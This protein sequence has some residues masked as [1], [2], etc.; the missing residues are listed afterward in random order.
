[1][2]S[3]M[4]PANTD[5][6]KD[7]IIGVVG[8]SH[9][10]AQEIL[11]ALSQQHFPKDQIRA[12][13]KQ[14]GH[15]R[16]ASYGENDE[17]DIE[18]L[19]TLTQGK[20][21][22]EVDILIF[23]GERKQ[24][25]PVQKRHTK[26]NGIMLD[27]SGAFSMHPD[28]PMIVPEINGQALEQVGSQRVI[29][30]PH[31]TTAMIAMCVMPLLTV[32]REKNADAT[33]RVHATI[34][35][36]VSHLGR[37]AMDELFNHTKSVF[38]NASPE[39]NI[40]PVPLPFNILPRTSGVRADE[41]SFDEWTVLTQLKKLFDGAIK[42]SCHI[43]QAPVFV[44]D[45]ITMD[46]DAGIEITPLNAMKHLSVAPGIGVVET[47]DGFDDEPV[48]QAVE[49]EDVSELF[50]DED[51]DTVVT[52]VEVVGEDL[53]F[54][55]RVRQDIMSPSGLQMV[56]VGDNL[57]C[58]VGLTVIKLVDLWLKRHHTAAEKAGA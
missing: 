6:A 55:T 32:A 31:P 53:C 36:S 4:K 28:V 14:G 52:P 11:V 3:Q 8:V 7:T 39:S 51:A 1:M 9:P 41:H 56:A 42:P 24:A 50:T 35:R 29:S 27:L 46:V 17:I 38:M 49:T 43:V 21:G 20:A 30:V 44:G 5:Y 34:M 33:L 57:R 25:A 16:Q 10:R 54:V 12:F 2:V 37:E 47:D 19:E 45:T 13:D 26:Q 22:E 18:K 15:G 23:A 40:F 48:T 58:G